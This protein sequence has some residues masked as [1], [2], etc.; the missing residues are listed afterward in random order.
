VT[1][2]RSVCFKFENDCHNR[3]GDGKTNAA[4]HGRCLIWV[5]LS[6]TDSGHICCGSE[7]GAPNVSIAH[8]PNDAKSAEKCF[9]HGIAWPVAPST[10]VAAAAAQDPSGVYYGSHMWNVGWWMFFGPLMMILSIAAI[11]IVV[12]L[13]VRW[14]GEPSHGA[15]PQRHPG[16]T[17]LDILKERFARG[18]I[19][20]PEFDERR[21]VLEE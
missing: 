2:A 10:S 12:A 14:L 1:C 6:A 11:I 16:K 5:N 8:A 20:K 13:V 19:D 17:P 7:S 3:C 21:Q 9:G 4:R 15:A 18:E